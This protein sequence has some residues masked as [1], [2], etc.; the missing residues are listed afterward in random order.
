MNTLKKSL[1]ALVASLTLVGG[2]N[3]QNINPGSVLVLYDASGTYGWIGG[4]YTRLLGNLLGHFPLLPYEIMPVENYRSND[5]NLARATFYLGSVYDNALPEAFKQ[6]VLA[7]TNTICWFK[8]NPW[9]IGGTNFE[10]KTG[11]RFNWLDWSGYSNIVYKGESFL[12]NQL[13]PELGYVT[14]LDT[15]IA[16]VYATAE[17]A[18]GSSIPYVTHGGNFWYIGDI[19][20]AYMS[21]EDRYIVFADLLHDILG[22]EHEHTKSALIRIEDVAPGMYTPQELRATADLLYNNGVPFVVALVPVYTDPL[23]VY[24]GGVGITNRM[25]DNTTTAQDFVSAIRYMVSKGGQLLLHGYTHQ[26]SNVPNPYNGCTGDDFEFWRETF[27]TNTV[28]DL[29]DLDIYAPIPE[30]STSWVMGRINAARQEAAAVG[31]SLVGFEAPHYAASALDY[32]IIATNF[33]L[34]MHRVLYFDDQGHVAGQMFPYVIHE[35]LYGQTVIPENLGNIE[36]VPWQNYPARFADDMIRAA[37]KNLVVRDGWASGYFHPFFDLTNLTAV[38]QGVKALGYTYVPL[39]A[40]ASPTI[41]AQ[42]IGQTVIAGSTVTLSVDAVGTD[43]LTYQWRRN[44]TAIAGATSATFSIANVQSADA[45]NYTVIVSNPYGSVTS[46]TATLSVVSAPVITSQPVSRTNAVGTTASFSVS[47]TGSTP[48]RYQW[49]KDGANILNATNATLSL[50][51]VQL[52]N[53]GVY[54]VLVTNVAGSVLSS[55][56]TLTVGSAPTITTQPASQ[57][58]KRGATVTF[59]VTATGTAPLRYQWRKD[60]VNLLNATNS[61]YKI[62]NAQTSD[63]GSYSVVVANDFGSKTSSNARL[64]VR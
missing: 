33:P 35:D 10:A 55:N 2:A 51:N 25:S 29:F 54:S 4:L 30:D 22:I 49:R 24:N 6:D 32:Q 7:T 47:A 59:S 39:P 1:L 34:T 9:Q 52:S 53:A 31:L 17:M 45:G 41:I 11:F 56:A 57:T 40:G 50:S 14:V 58:V 64:K 62:T 12:K 36:P 23:G 16:T 42:P 46:D 37:R 15:N 21:E 26:Y 13:D 60:G 5:V 63:A 61:T 3:A 48:L 8:Y 18:D 20:F 44:G 43:P 19:P 38:I 28:D 27:N